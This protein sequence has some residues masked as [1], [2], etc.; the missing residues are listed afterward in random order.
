MEQRLEHLTATYVDLAANVVAVFGL[1]TG[2]RVV[3]L[4]DPLVDYLVVQCTIPNFRPAA[5]S[6]SK[7]CILAT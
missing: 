6:R 4:D 1:E 5:H 3:R 7:A 2:L